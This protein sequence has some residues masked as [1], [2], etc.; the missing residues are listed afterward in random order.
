MMHLGASVM[1][2]FPPSTLLYHICNYYKILN[3]LNCHVLVT[4]LKNNEPT[5][6]SVLKNN[7]PTWHFFA[8]NFP[9]EGCIKALWITSWFPLEISRTSQSGRCNELDIPVQE[10]HKG[11]RSYER[12]RN[13]GIY[14]IDE[15]FISSLKSW[16]MNSG[17]REKS[18]S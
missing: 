6:H 14:L 11:L 15:N 18:N 2:S 8:L 12:F 13:C 5:W 1:R 10:W 9:K 4:V 16:G 7:E 17:I 3:L